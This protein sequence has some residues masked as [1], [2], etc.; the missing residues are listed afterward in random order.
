VKVGRGSAR[1]YT[2]QDAVQM[3]EHYDHLEDAKTAIES[4]KVG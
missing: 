4:G 2:Y 1:A 3:R